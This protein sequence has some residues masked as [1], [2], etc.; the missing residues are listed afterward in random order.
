MASIDQMDLKRL[1]HLLAL[2][3]EPHFGRAADRVTLSHPA[4]QAVMRRPPLRR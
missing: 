4:W 2:A 3:D 1:T